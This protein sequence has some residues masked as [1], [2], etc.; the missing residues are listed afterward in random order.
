LAS[1]TSKP[2]GDVITYTITVANAGNVTL[3]GVNVTDQVES[4]GVTNAV[5][6]SGDEA[7]LG[8]LNVGETWTYSAAYTLTQ[9]DLDNA[10][11]GDGDLDNVATAS[12]NEHP[13][14]SD[15]ASVPVLQNA[16]IELIKSGIFQDENND[17][18]ADAGETISYTFTVTNTGNVT[19]TNVTLADTVGGVT[20]SG[21]RIATLAVG[22]VDSTTFTGSYT[23]TQA[24]IDSGSF[25]N[26]A[27]VTG[28]DPNGDPVSDPD[29][30]TEPLPQAPS[31][32]L[33]KTG[34]FQDEKND[35]NADVGET[36]SYTFTVTN[37][38]DVTLGNVTLADTVGGVTI[39]GGPI[40]TLV[41]GAVDSTTFTGSYTLTQADIDNGSFFNTA[42]I[43]GNDPNGD[44][45]SDQD[46]HTEPLPRAPAIT[47][48]K[49]VTDVGGDGPSGVVDAAGDVVAYRIEVA[50]VGNITISGVTVSDPLVATL[51]R[52]SDAPG[53]NNNNLLDVGE[54]WVYTGTYTAQQLDID[55]NGTSEPNDILAAFLDNTA[56]VSSDQLPDQSDSASVPVEQPTGWIG[57]RIWLDQDGD[58]LQDAGEYGIA[59]VTVRLYDATGAVLFGST[60]TDA[61]GLYVFADLPSDDYLVVVDTS[62]LPGG[63]AANQ[64]GDPDA[65]LDSQTPVTLTPGQAVNTADFGYRGPGSIGTTV[66]FD[67]NNDGMPDSGEGLPE[68]TVTRTGDFDGDGIDEVFTTTT[69]NA[70]GDYLFA[71]LPTGVQYTV[72]VDPQTL[73]LGVMNTVDPDGTFDG[74]STATPTQASPNPGYLDFGYRNDPNEEPDFTGNDQDP[75][76][77][78][79]ASWFELVPCQGNFN[80]DV[81]YA[82]AGNGGSV[83]TWHFTGLTPGVY[84]VS[85]TWE[86]LFGSPRAS[87]APFTVRGANGETPVTNRIDQTLTPGDYPGA[88]YDQ[89]FYWVDIASF[90]EIDGFSLFVDL[91]ND[92]DNYV[93]ADAI[94]VQRIMSAEIA[95]SESGSDVADGSGVVNFGMTSLNT[96]VSKTFTVQN[97]G[98]ADLTLST[99]INVPSGFTVTSSFGSTTLATGQ[100][101]TFTVRYDAAAYGATSGQLSFGNN[102]GDEN[103]FNFTLTG[104]TAGTIIDNGDAGCSI[105][106][107]WLNSTSGYL[108]DSQYAPAGTGASK[109]NWAFS[110]LTT[111]QTYEVWATWVASGNR[112]TNAPY[113]L[114]N[115]SVLAGNL[116]STAVV[117][118]QQSPSGQTQGGVVWQSLG[119][120]T[121]SGSTLTV[122][123]TNNA[124][125]YVLAD[126]I[127]IRPTSAPASAA[128]IVVQVGAVNVADNSGDVDFGSTDPGVVV[129][130][131]FTVSN[132]GT[133]PLTLGAI[134]SSSADFTAT[135]FGAT[136]LNPGQST[137]FTVTMSSSLAGNCSGTISFATND[138]DEN[139]FNFSVHGTV[140]AAAS[141]PQIID[142]GD[143]GYWSG[144]CWSNYSGLGYGSDLQYSAGGSGTNAA[145]WTFTGLTAGQTYQ[146][147]TT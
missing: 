94:R 10:G 132:T 12:A 18:N 91:S 65:T 76:F 117:N 11:G 106:N 74:S 57:D 34:T 25:F 147:S 20:I 14:I 36:I 114:Y 47:I 31:I 42:T 64:T 66:F 92:A 2:A 4:Y 123:L 9:A 137:T 19:L 112:A 105:S 124:N 125:G 59:N 110:G 33:V 101:T 81:S 120:V 13:E 43:T 130:Q 56:T 135:G 82:P 1:S 72:T 39:S 111:G 8:E 78:T 128:E 96:P 28:T 68:I 126:A 52:G 61:D 16:G 129:M 30:H 84:R 138:A 88:I 143:A 23:I 40:A 55:S 79:T 100:S 48:A 44:P 21:G 142:N 109:A 26:T 62:T 35:G 86:T 17:G 113:G 99:P 145:T 6:I 107:T 122:Q 41:V 46:D 93:V 133:A 119:M 127:Q 102:D 146:V 63:M 73:P 3:T 87:N 32:E 22:A 141:G 95:V 139:P 85:V 83:G 45:I 51:I 80:N 53:N 89:G 108:S 115:G 54:V 116:V 69:T 5:Y 49:S 29:D 134:S 58:G 15:Q 70:V 140:V 103:P 24:D 118:Q 77:T 131:T 67:T 7:P 90:Y 104:E 97:V 71:D 37:T 98:G 121:V 136:T 50:N 27:T 38:G 60:V 75:M 144:C